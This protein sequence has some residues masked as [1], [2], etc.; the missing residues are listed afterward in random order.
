M[1]NTYVKIA[2]VTA[3]AGGVTSFDFTNIPSTYSDLVLKLSARSSSTAVDVRIVF[4]ANTSNYSR[5]NI[6]G[7]GSAAS[8]S[9][10]ADATAQNSG[11]RQM[12]VLQFMNYSNANTNKT[13]LS[14]YSSV[15]CN[16]QPQRFMEYR[17]PKETP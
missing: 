17:E 12:F 3:G 16:I 10:F 8:S 2:S 4:N 7:N 13:F 15:G 5:R 1:A 9:S 14:R 11:T 6:M